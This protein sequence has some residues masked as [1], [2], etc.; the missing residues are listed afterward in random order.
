MS[1]TEFLLGLN[2]VWFATLAA[3]GKDAN[4]LS[5]NEGSS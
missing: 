1:R 4:K 2:L 5:L 3:S